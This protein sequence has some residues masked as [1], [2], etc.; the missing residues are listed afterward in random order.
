RNDVRAFTT[1]HALANFNDMTLNNV[2]K[3]Y[4]NGSSSCSKPL[5][6]LKDI[7]I[8]K[9][10]WISTM[11]TLDLSE[12]CN[13]STMKV[14]QQWQDIKIKIPI[15]VGKIIKL[16]SNKKISTIADYTG[17]MQAIIHEKVL[18][19][20]SQQLQLG[21]ILVLKNVAILRSIENIYLNVTLTNICLISTPEQLNNLESTLP[22]PVSHAT[23]V[24]LTYRH[25]EGVGSNSGNQTNAGSSDKNDLTVNKEGS[26]C[27]ESTRINESQVEVTS[28]SN[29][30]ENDSLMVSNIEDPEDISWMLDDLEEVVLVD[31]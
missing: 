17:K 4:R 3:R 12:N 11:R 22:C 2:M 8:A 18:R 28:M 10:E 21:S 6:P 27:G 31:F 20:H 24:D 29:D 15:T 26:E 5:E 19:V 13:R 30:P 9:E 14:L 23:S 25:N 1:R 16:D 7:E